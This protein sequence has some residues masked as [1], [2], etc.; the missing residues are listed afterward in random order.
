MERTKVIQEVRSKLRNKELFDCALSLPTGRKE[1]RLVKQRL[2]FLGD[3]IIELALS[4]FLFS[5]MEKADEGVL[6]RVRSYLVSKGAMDKIA[7]ELGITSD[8]SKGRKFACDTL[9]AIIGA[10]FL[11]KGIEKAF[12]FVLE[13]WGPLISSLGIEDLFAEKELLQRILQRHRKGVPE[14]MTTGENGD[15]FC[16]VFFEGEE[17][18]AGKGRTKKEAQTN[19]AKNALEKI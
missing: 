2:E 17:L 3:S 12:S 1:R 6:T 18:G 4:L 9:E 7:A 8:F 13:L 15:F 10:V 5:S 14:Y 16:R 11:D 19:A